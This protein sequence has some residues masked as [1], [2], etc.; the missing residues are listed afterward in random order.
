MWIGLSSIA[1]LDQNEMIDVL[2]I[3]L[4]FFKKCDEE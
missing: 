1:S 4:M 2:G 3:G